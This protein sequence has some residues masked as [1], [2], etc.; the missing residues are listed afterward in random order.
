[1]NPIQS[2]VLKPIEGGG[3]RTARAEADDRHQPMIDDKIRMNPT[4]FFE[5]EYEDEYDPPSPGLRRDEGG[6]G[7]LSKDGGGLY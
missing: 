5:D 3:N 1:M 7:F 2:T 4:C 6:G